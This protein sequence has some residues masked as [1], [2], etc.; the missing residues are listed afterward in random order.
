M[1]EYSS[2]LSLMQS[3][4]LGNSRHGDWWVVVS[5]P[6]SYRWEG[7][8][9]QQ[10]WAGWGLWSR[11]DWLIIVFPPLPCRWKP[12]AVVCRAKALSWMGSV[13]QMLMKTG[14]DPAHTHQHL[15]CRMSGEEHEHVLSF[16]QH[17]ANS[18]FLRGAQQ[19]D[20]W[21]VE[22][23]PD[24]PEMIDSMQHGLSRQSRTSLSQS[25]AHMEIWTGG[26]TVGLSISVV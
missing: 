6:L 21:R 12:W 2:P 3:G 26:E 9:T 14:W 22:A 16:Q 25:C 11:T 8:F 5:F 24:Q 19:W 10:T 17:T 15:S 20:E 23:C 18:L 13:V 1:S 4:S 7:Y